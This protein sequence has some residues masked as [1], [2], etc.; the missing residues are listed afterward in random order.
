MIYIERHSILKARTLSVLR[1]GI[2]IYLQ[3]GFGQNHGRFILVR[4][5]D[6]KTGTE[7]HKSFISRSE[8]SSQE[9]EVLRAKV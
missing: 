3:D 2:D 9:N 8:I 1:S 7:E 5:V 6:E 4:T